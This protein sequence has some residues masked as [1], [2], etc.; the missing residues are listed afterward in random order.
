MSSARDTAAKL[1]MGTAHST[2]PEPLLLRSGAEALSAWTLDASIRHLN[3]GSYGG[4][5]RVAQIA[6]ME[7]RAQMEARPGAWF[8]QL[9]QRVAGA[10][11]Q[12]SDFLGVDV[13]DLALVLNTSAGV[14]AVLN[15][16]ELT[17]GD[18]ILMTDHTYP[19]V[20]GG[21]ERLARRHHATT[22]KATVPLDADEE[23]SYYA[24]TA[25][26]TDRT[27]LV[28]LDHVTAQTARSMPLGRI[29][30]H[31]HAHGAKV[32][33]DGAHAPGLFA[34]PLD[35]HSA[36]YWVGNLHKFPCAPRGAAALVARGDVKKSLHPLIDSWGYA[37]PFPASY[38]LQ[39]TLDLTSY[40]AAPAA[41][42][43]VEDEWG[44]ATARA[45]MSTLATYGQQT[46][47][48][49]LTS[50][51]NENHLP[52]V[53]MP[54]NALRLVRLGP[55]CT[56]EERAHRNSVLTDLGVSVMITSYAGADYLRLSA[57]VYNTSTDYEYFADRCVPA[58]IEFE[59]NRSH[60]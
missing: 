12:V 54:V 56:P 7:L 41:F 6:Q 11:V 27:R 10:R 9:G 25:Q 35:G 23:A 3:H 26:I 5:P 20:A 18:E 37:H 58:L 15:S 14:S 52:E 21:I 59:R 17:P 47:A 38:D 49:A 30:A 60:E 28:V 33:V 29:V 1:T 51:T 36:D 43:M 22:I 46:I 32:L 40:L 42:G 57:H 50:R 34:R 24:V 2:R 44:W 8:S 39:G 53:G 31:A 19:A 13:D 55:S 48:A 45:Y 16:I 4:V